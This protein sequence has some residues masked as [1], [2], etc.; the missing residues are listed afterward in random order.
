MAFRDRVRVFEKTLNVF[1]KAS[2]LL[3]GAEG[4]QLHISAIPK[5][6][7]GGESPCHVQLDRRR[8]LFTI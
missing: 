6:E 8:V 1:F 5:F 3:Y 7:S 4:T 2:N